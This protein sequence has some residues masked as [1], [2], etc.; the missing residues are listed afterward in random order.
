MSI[1]TYRHNGYIIILELWQ[2]CREFW[3]RDHLDN[4]DRE[5]ILDDDED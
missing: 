2:Y 3:R 4:K 1:P 5:M